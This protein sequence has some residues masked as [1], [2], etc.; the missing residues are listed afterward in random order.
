MVL[1]GVVTIQDT[2]PG[3]TIYYTTDGNAP[4]S[5]STPYTAPFSVSVS[6]TVKA[7][8]VLSGGQSTIASSTLT[9]NIP[10]PPAMLAFTQQPSNVLTGS[11][12]SPP[13]Q[14]A[15]EDSNGN[16]V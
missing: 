9:I 16:L 1:P 6:S 10:P 15:I 7:I 5:S 13:V 11:N 14:V 12:I 8:A 4:S 2:T 3:S